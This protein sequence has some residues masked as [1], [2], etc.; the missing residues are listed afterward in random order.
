MSP[1]VDP[2]NLVRLDRNRF[3]IREGHIDVM[4]YFGCRM[5]VTAL[6]S[7]PLVLALCSVFWG[8]SLPYDTASMGAMDFTGQLISESFEHSVLLFYG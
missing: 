7:A 4:V 6:C 3:P 2:Q 1:V 5:C 8:L